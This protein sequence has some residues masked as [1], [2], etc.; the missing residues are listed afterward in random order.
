MTNPEKQAR[1]ALIERLNGENPDKVTATDR[2]R[3]FAHDPET[4]DFDQ[5]EA[6]NLLATID[7]A[8]DAL[9]Q[10]DDGG[11]QSGGVSAAVADVL[12]ERRRQVE[13]EGWTP[14]HDDA[15]DRQELAAAAACYAH[16]SP[17]MTKFRTEG[18]GGALHDYPRQVPSDWPWHPQWWKPTDRRRD[19]VKAGALVLAEI[20]RL[21]RA[22]QPPEMPA[23]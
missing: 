9:R 17:S 3:L 13:A 14:A 20:E 10:H 18:Y 21:D 6:I 12:A 22:E 4:F 8:V 5:D 19:L 16:P 7:E 2:L 1:E 23:L 11:A 15:H